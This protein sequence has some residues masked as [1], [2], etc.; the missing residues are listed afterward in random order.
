MRTPDERAR[1]AAAKL[2]SMGATFEFRYYPSITS[3]QMPHG[4][5]GV[6]T[7]RLEGLRATELNDAHR[8]LPVATLLERGDDTLCDHEWKHCKASNDPRWPE[9]DKCKKC[10]FET[11]PFEM[12]GL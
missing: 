10:G 9:Y 8:P 2:I 1:W 5:D 4:T 3:Q 11:D 7:D 6:R 12:N